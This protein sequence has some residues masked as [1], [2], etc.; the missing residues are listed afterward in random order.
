MKISAIIPNYNKEKTIKKCIE[1]IYREK[2]DIE[3]IVVDDCSKDNSIRII[4]ENFPNLAIIVNKKNKGAAYCRNIGM[5]KSKGE[6]ILFLDSDIILKQGSIKNMLESI[7]EQDIS[8]PRIVYLNGIVMQPINKKEL[9]YPAVSACFMIKNDSLKKLDEPFDETYKTFNED[10][11]FFVR[12]RLFDLKAKYSKKAIAFHNVESSYNAEERYYLENRNIIYGILK[13]MGVKR[14]MDIEHPFKISS[15]FKN[16]I[17][18]IF[19]FRWFDWS[20]YNRKKRFLSKFLLLFKGNNKI[21]KKSRFILLYLFLKA[22][23]WNI[24]NIR[25]IISKRK[26]LISKLKGKYETK[27]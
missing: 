3:I 14:K 21:T 15:L 9:I 22:F 19:N 25:L 20:L 6:F 18:G 8:F 11:D 13:L 10:T 12:C 1:S 5:S 27:R 24:L 4:K 16:F 26:R 7:K 17:C 2:K 23:L